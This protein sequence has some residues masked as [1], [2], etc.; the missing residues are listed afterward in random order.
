[1][2]ISRHSFLTKARQLFLGALTMPAVAEAASPSTT[3]AKDQA[4]WATWYDLPEDRH[5]EH[6][7]WVHETHIPMLLKNDNY[8]WAAH[9]SSIPDGTAARIKH[10]TDA[11]VPTGKDYILL[12]GGKDGNV[13]GAPTPD[14]VHAS[15]PEASKRMLAMRRNARWNIFV[16]ASRVIGPGFPHYKDGMTPAPCIQFG[17][18]CVDEQK[19]IDI[20]AWYAQLQ[21]PVMTTA[22]GCVRTRKL[23]SVAG[24]AKMGIFYEFASV[25]LRNHHFTG[26]KSGV[27]KW[28]ESVFALQHAPGSPNVARRT[29]PA[30]R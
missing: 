8:L 15:L 19:E 21:M 13:F 5:E 11:G 24:W 28:G 20:L 27:G 30:V 3:T 2:G 12:I 9:Y 6:L 29:W 23:A 26:D 14:E 7:T 1:M 10:T 4:M 17:T 22:D 16:D 18:Y 25:E